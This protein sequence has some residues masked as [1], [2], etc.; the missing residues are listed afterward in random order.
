M[1]HA[2]AVQSHAVCWINARQAAPPQHYLTRFEV[3]GVAGL[4]GIVHDGTSA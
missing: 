3:P 4:V 2:A 1:R